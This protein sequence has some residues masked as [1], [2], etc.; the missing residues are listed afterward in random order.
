MLSLSLVCL[1]L[2]KNAIVLSPFQVLGVLEPVEL[3]DTHCPT[4][5]SLSY[6]D[7]FTA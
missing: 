2:R 3:I 7:A 5:N 1:V 6:D 4:Q